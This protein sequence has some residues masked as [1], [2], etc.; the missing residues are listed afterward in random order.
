MYKYPDNSNDNA[1][2][3]YVKIFQR[4]IVKGVAVNNIRV[5]SFMEELGSSVKTLFGNVI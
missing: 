5:Y 1:L 3:E 4:I 2:G